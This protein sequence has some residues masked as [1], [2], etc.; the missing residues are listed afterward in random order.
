M[1]VYLL[2]D[3]SDDVVIPSRVVLHSVTLNKTAK[4]TLLDAPKEKMKWKVT[5]DGVEI[6]STAIIAK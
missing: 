2:S 6:A 3:K 4:I 5:S 1:Y